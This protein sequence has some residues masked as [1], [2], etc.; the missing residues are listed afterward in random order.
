MPNTIYEGG[1]LRKSYTRL[2]KIPMN[3]VHIMLCNFC[4]LLEIYWPE[5]KYLLDQEDGSIKIMFPLMCNQ[6]CINF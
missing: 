1:V 5:T 6:A 3:E 2:P 4:I